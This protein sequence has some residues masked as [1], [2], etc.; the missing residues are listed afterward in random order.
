[1][2]FLERERERELLA[3]IDNNCNNS[4]V[5]GANDFLLSPDSSTSNVEIFTI[6]VRKQP[7]GSHH[8]TGSLVH[9]RK[10]SLINTYMGFWSFL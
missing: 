7:N 6:M 9:R 3:I 4:S 2:G 10:F 5:K 1:M 8:G